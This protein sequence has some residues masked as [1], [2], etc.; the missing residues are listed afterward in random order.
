[1][2]NT[3]A[4]PILANLNPPQHEAVTYGDGPLLIFAGAGSGKTRV[5]THRIAYLMREGGARAEEI[6]AV[7]FTNKAANEMK[8]R[9]GRLVGRGVRAMWVG[10]F[11]AI[12]ARILRAD[13]EAIGIPSNYVIFDTEDQLTVVGD[14]LKELGISTANGSGNSRLKPNTVL[15]RISD[16]KNDLLDPDDFAK[17]ARTPDEQTIAKIYRMYQEHLRAN[18]AL[19]FD[20]L[21]MKTVELLQ[22]CPQVLGALH[23]RFRYVFV[24]EYQDINLAQYRFVTLLAQAHRNLCVVGDDDQS[25]YTWRGAD[26][27]LLLRFERDYP[28][29]HVVKLEQNYRSPQTILD[30]AYHVICRNKT[31]KE[32]RLWTERAGGDRLQCYRAADEHG[33]AAFIAR[34]IRD[35]VRHQRVRYKEVAVLY[36]I[37]A[38]SRVLEQMMISQGIP[39]RIVGGLKFFARKEIKDIIAYL[40][41]LYNP[42]DTVSLRR[43]INVPTRGIGATTLSRLEELAAEQRVSLF[44]MLLRVDETDLAARA[45]GAVRTFATM[46]AGFMELAGQATITELIGRIITDSGYEQMLL[47]EGTV[48]AR[49]RLENIR[50]LLSESQ[51][52]EAQAEDDEGRSLRAFLEQISLVTEIE[53]T[54]EGE[55]AVTLMTLHAAKGL[56]FPVVFLTGME[57]GVFPLARAVMSGNANDLEE[58]RRLCYVGITRAGTHLY[59]TLSESRTLFGATTYNNAPSRFLRDIPDELIVPAEDGYAPRPAAPTWD[60]TDAT[61]HAPA[62]EAIILEA[63]PRDAGAFKAGDRV[64]HKAFG[65]GMV[66]AIQGSTRVTVNFPRLGTK[67]LD[68]TFAPLEKL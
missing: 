13:G 65:D 32:K 11:H 34:M 64:R 54:E 43:I 47:E 60:G 48:Q 29:A 21:I 7:T 56:E 33:E 61:R 15:G 20:D 50:E 19:D 41:V 1:M 68:L 5:L 44:Q 58:E 51:E 12:C 6:L 42:D 16:A 45:Q 62:A 39:Y 38:L 10:T 17:E 9:I 27:R 23:A 18:N 35:L 31:R 36:R 67:T 30:A 2:P 55:D 25:I 52:F 53:E 49:T 63:S 24:D 3:A 37:N 26:S 59:C 28:E 22:G 40:R 46:M 57:E 8:E 14:C 66:L 4:D